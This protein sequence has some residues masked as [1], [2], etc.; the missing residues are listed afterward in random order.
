MAIDLQE[1]VDLTSR[2]LEQPALIEDRDF[3]LVAFHSQTAGID[4]VRQRSILERGSSDEVRAWF[5]QFGIATAAA[6][7]RTPADE[8]RG[9]IGRLCVPA[10]WN[11]VNHGYLWVLDPDGLV[12]SL[13]AVT[14]VQQLAAHAGALLAQRAMGRHDE[15]MLLDAL[16]SPDIAR[17]THA[18]EE[19]TERQMLSAGKP[20]VV[21]EVSL[22]PAGSSPPVNIWSLPRGVLAAVRP[23][24]A[25]L[26][27]PLESHGDPVPARRAA[28]EIRRQHDARVG[29]SWKG[30]LVIGIGDEQPSLREARTSH[31]RATI[32][33]RVAALEGQ[34]HTASWSD[35]GVYRLLGCG[36]ESELANSVLDA[37]VRAL[38]G[39]D[40]SELIRTAEVY[41]E[42]AGSVRRTSDRLGIHRQTT[43]YRIRRI[44]EVTKLDL[45]TGEDRLT[46][47]LGLRLAPLLWSGAATALP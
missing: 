46:L 43:Y 29:P 34:P 31:R 25:T 39:H 36:P 17:A 10:R 14:E 1:I 4:V 27:V 8:E 28:L 6:P 24:R 16:M 22:Q 13:P 5:E 42:E 15:S 30:R 47:H 20:V 9:T 35:L 41:L 38:L 45:A 26:L 18:A 37:R 7:V 23:G 19:L 12:G 21:V 33:A 32:A 3:N 44:S 2:L 11:G 40:D